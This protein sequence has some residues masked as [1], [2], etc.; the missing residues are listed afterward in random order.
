MR[1]KRTDGRCGSRRSSPWPAARRRASRHGGGA[2][3]MDAE[4]SV[5]PALLPSPA[6]AS[7]VP[8]T[9]GRVRATRGQG[10]KGR[11]TRTAM[12]G[13][14]ERRRARHLRLGLDC[15]Q[16]S[17][18]VSSLRGVWT[19]STASSLHFHAKLPNGPHFGKISYF[20]HYSS[21]ILA[22]LGDIRRPHAKP[23]RSRSWSPIHLVACP[24]LGC[25]GACGCRGSRP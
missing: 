7:R 5:R 17:Q 19:A 9:Q 10:R 25:P 6:P 1:R 4:M 2:G 21:L 16:T 12:P 14:R 8:A 3:R 24:R 22:P 11:A 23:A 20:I 18:A 15:R 13:P